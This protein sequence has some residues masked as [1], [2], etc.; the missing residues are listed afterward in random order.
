VIERLDKSSERRLSRKKVD[1]ERL[2][3]QKDI[4]GAAGSEN[5]KS[6][7]EP[8]W[9]NYDIHTN[10]TAIARASEVSPEREKMLREGNAGRVAIELVHKMNAARAKALVQKRCELRKIEKLIGDGSEL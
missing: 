8:E 2:P 5:C 6:G 10:K 1:T 9:K 4:P 7:I 3:G